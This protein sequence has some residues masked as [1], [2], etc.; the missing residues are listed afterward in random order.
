M[1]PIFSNTRRICKLTLTTSIRGPQKGV[2]VERKKICYNPDI[3]ID[4][5]FRHWIENVSKDRKGRS[6]DGRCRF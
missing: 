4:R 2:I 5:A 1:D 6:K 3:E